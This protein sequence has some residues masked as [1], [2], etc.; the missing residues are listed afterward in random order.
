MRSNYCGW[1]KPIAPQWDDELMNQKTQG[2][3]KEGKQ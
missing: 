3:E 2:K 1:T